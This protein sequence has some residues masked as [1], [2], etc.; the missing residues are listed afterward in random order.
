MSADTNLILLMRDSPGKNQGAVQ[1]GR[2]DYRHY[3]IT[4][5]RLAQAACSNGRALPSAG[6]G[7]HSA[8]GHVPLAGVQGLIAS[9]FAATCV[10]HSLAAG[11]AGCT[12]R[13]C[14]SR[15]TSQSSPPSPR[16]CSRCSTRSSGSTSTCRSCR[17]SSSSLSTPRPPSSWA[18]IPAP[19]R[20]AATASST[21]TAPPTPQPRRTARPPPPLP[22]PSAPRLVPACAQRGA[23]RARR[24]WSACG[25]ASCGR[26]RLPRDTRFRLPRDALLAAPRDPRARTSPAQLRAC[27]LAG[28]GSVP[29]FRAS[30]APRASKAPCVC[31]AAVRASDAACVGITSPRL[32]PFACTGGRVLMLPCFAGGAGGG[33]ACVWTRCS[34]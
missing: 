22:P 12:A 33:A 3:A 10:A 24:R 27:R 16:R 5:Q 4:A 18:S 8:A 1:P 9:C 25:S 19:S 6:Q 2:Q 17:C 30:V 15:A 20:P 26:F 29:R 21:G 34:W 32:L 28:V 13:C 23:R 14:S 31:G 7:E 11:T